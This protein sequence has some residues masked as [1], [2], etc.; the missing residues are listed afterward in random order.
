M[1]G[2]LIWNLWNELVYFCI[3]SGDFCHMLIIAG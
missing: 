3:A 2:H 1:S